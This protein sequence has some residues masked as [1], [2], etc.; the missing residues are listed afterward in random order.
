M[1]G[2]A[3]LGVGTWTLSEKWYYIYL[4]EDTTYKVTS[5]HLLTTSSDKLL[6]PP[7]STIL[8]LMLTGLVAVLTGVLGYTA[9]LTSSK[10]LLAVVSH[11]SSL[12]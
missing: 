12:L 8:L 9:I 3:I 10:P 2:S 5:C 11:Q 7:Q 4:I 1:C 6:L